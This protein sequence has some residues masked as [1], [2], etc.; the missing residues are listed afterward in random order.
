MRDREERARAA[1]E[2]INETDFPQDAEMGADQEEARSSGASGPR[3]DIE[4]GNVIYSISADKKLV[5]R[6]GSVIRQ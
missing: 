6:E 2:V 5:A 4:T 3:N 1:P